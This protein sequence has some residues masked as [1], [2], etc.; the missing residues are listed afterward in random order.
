[1]FHRILVGSD[2]SSQSSGALRLAQ[3]LGQTFDA[4]IVVAHVVMMPAALQG[5]GSVG[6]RNDLKTYGSL[7]E[8]Q[9]AAARTHLE[10]QV[11][12]ARLASAGGVELVVR[13]GSPAPILA[14]LVEELD[15]D[16]VI[17]ARGA[18]GKLGPVA[19]Q[20][21]RLVGRTVLVAPVRLRRGAVLP[22]PTTRPAPRPRRRAAA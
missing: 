8:R 16:L 12:T 5:W 21:V 2:L 4:H 6:F 20:L 18:G 15:A 13:S 14:A 11:T 10:R 19:E 7:L 3:G 22:L 1:M 9:L 17:V